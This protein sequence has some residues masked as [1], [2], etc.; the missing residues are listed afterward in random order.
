MRLYSYK[1][2]IP[3]RLDYPLFAA[4]KRTVAKAVINSYHKSAGQF[5]VWAATLE[6]GIKGDIR[7]NVLNVKLT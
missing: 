5:L 7:W 3:I 2:I 1:I 4:F 6:F